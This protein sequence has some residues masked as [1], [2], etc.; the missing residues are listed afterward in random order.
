MASRLFTLLGKINKPLLLITILALFLRVYKI[1][2]YPVSLNWDEVAIGY[3]AHSLVET[4]KDEYSQKFPILFKSFND[5]KLPGYIY[6]DALFIKLF[7]LSETTVRL[8]SALFGT[9]AVPIFY[10][11]LKN[12]FNHSQKAKIA[13]NQ[14]LKNIP[15]FSAL[16]LAISPWHLQFSRA[17]FEANV[18]LSLMLTGILFLIISPKFKFF[19][20]ISLPTLA[21]SIYFY[22]SQRLIAPLIAISFFIIYR[23]TVTKNLKLYLLSLLISLFVLAPISL[24]FIKPEGTKRLKEVS[25]TS[26]E[27]LLKEHVFALSKNPSLVNS[28]FLNYRVPVIIEFFHNY[29]SHF[30]FGFLFFGDDPNPR[31]KNAIH[32]NF[33]YIEI[34]LILLG[35]WQLIKLEDKKTKYFII[36]WLLLSPLAASL[37]K[38]TPHSLRALPM[39]PPL[40]AISALGL[41]SILKNRFLQTSIVFLFT[42]SLINYL[43]NY[44]YLYPIKHN[45]SWAYGY[46]QLYE[47]L[48][49][50][51][52]N[53]DKVIVS[54]DNWK[55]YIFYLFYNKIDPYYYQNSRD[56]SSVG[57]Y[58]FGPTPWDSNGQYLDEKTV[59]MVKGKKTL[60]AFSKAEISRLENQQRFKKIFEIKDFSARNII[61]EVGEWE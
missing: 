41:A 15:L 32:G 7:G 23:S 18:A 29:F 4:Q 17:A 13:K 54:G 3:N 56:K 50:I 38:E 1:G 36:I 52:G 34:P 2:S 47:K 40:I 39:L 31:H 27:S 21:L 45:T 12:L 30:S 61:F 26:D 16:L 22:Y 57:K 44:F 51:D 19:A 6:L 53:Y 35:I 10:L 46:K 48:S 14:L 24:Y 55:P 37:A 59:D 25:I 11:L 43:I 8:P 9:L 49:K 33:Y 28:M 58:N 42:L 20:L 60:V 5:Y